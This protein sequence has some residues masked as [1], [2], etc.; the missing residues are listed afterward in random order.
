MGISVSEEEI[1][2]EIQG[3]IDES[4]DG[5]EEDFRMILEYYGLTY[6]AFKEDARLNLLVRKLAMENIDTSEESARQFFEENR[7][8]FDVNEEVEARHILVET[9]AE[10]DEVVARLREGDDFTELAAEYSTDPSNKDEGGYL[11]FFGRGMMVEEFE[12][13]AFTM[14]VGEISEP[15]ETSFGFHIIEVLGRVEAEEAAFEDVSD[16]VVETMIERNVS[17]IINE[18]VQELYAEADIEYLL[19]N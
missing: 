16:R 10:A 9:E 12:D 18:I 19:E 15:V 4:F 5:S 2:E 1:N 8:L 6:D 3:I 11:G 14:E 17:T 13:A 7:Q